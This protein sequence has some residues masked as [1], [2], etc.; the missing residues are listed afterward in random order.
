MSV[1][2]PDMG[3]F[4]YVKSG[5]VY[6][7]NNR[8]IDDKYSESISSHCRDRFTEEEA[9]R[10]TKNLLLLNCKSYAAR[11]REKLD[12][13]RP[14]FKDHNVPI[15]AVQL[16]KYLQCIQYNIELRTIE[17]GYSEAD[18]KS[19]KFDV[20]EQDRK[21]VKL[22]DDFIRDIQYSIVSQMPEYANAKYSEA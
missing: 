6:A 7:A 1:L 15:K 8:S 5:F 22:L 19:V 12:D 21:D 3:V 10:W 17:N 13:L 14:F 16:L 18:E 11:Y 4:T 2:I 9:V 20:T